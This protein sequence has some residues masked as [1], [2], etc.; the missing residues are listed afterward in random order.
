MLYYN[1]RN[2]GYHC[3]EC[4]TPAHVLD[5]EIGLVPVVYFDQGDMIKRA[6]GGKK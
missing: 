3:A 6:H 4:K 5:K 1:G 2:V